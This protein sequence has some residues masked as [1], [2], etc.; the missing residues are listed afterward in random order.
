MLKLLVPRDF[1]ESWVCSHHWPLHHSL[2]HSVSIFTLHSLSSFSADKLGSECFLG[3]PSCSPSCYSEFL[4]PFS[5]GKSGSG[6]LGD[7]AGAE[8]P[9]WIGAE[10]SAWKQVQGHLS[11][12]FKWIWKAFIKF[13]LCSGDYDKIPYIGWPYISSTCAL[14]IKFTWAFMQERYKQERHK[15]RTLI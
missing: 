13:F 9:P 14:P 7:H 4:A 5:Y 1:R 15:H 3:S 2:L 10:G 8:C 12:L 6:L 11:I